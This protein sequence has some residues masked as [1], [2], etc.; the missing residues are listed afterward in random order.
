MV[1]AAADFDFK[2][3]RDRRGKKCLVHFCG[4]HAAWKNLSVGAFFCFDTETCKMA[5]KSQVAVGIE[6]RSQARTE[7]S[8]VRCKI[9]NASAAS[10]IALSPS[11]EKKLAPGF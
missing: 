7:I 3:G 11:G 2:T 9:L 6:N 4:A 10:K 5:A 1:R 8:I